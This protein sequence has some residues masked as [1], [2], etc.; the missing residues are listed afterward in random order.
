MEIGQRIRQ[1]R[2]EQGYTQETLG[3]KIGMAEKYISGIE[4]GDREELLK[5]HITR[6]VDCSNKQGG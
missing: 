1:I 5:Q 2:I 6:L 3:K 4:T